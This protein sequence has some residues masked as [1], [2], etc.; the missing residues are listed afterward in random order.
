M[1]GHDAIRS[2]P[3]DPPPAP[4]RPPMAQQQPPAPGHDHL[5]AMA[6]AMGT[7]QGQN[8]DAIM[9]QL[10]ALQTSHA[11]TKQL[12]QQ[13]SMGQRPQDQSPSPGL[14]Q[15]EAFQR[16]GMPQSGSSDGMSAQAQQ[17][18]SMSQQQ[19]E[20]FLA[21]Q[22]RLQ[23]GHAQG[24]ARPP[25][26]QHIQQ[27]QGF[28]KSFAQYFHASGQTPP[29]A[30]F[31]NGEREGCFRVG[32]YWMDVVDLLMAVM[33]SGGIMA[34]MQQPPDSP[35]WRMLLS[36]KG[37]PAVLP[38]PIECPKPPNSDPNS[39]PT[40]TTNPVT[41]LSSAYFAWIQGFEVNMQKNR[42]ASYM[43]QQQ[44]AIAAGRPPPAPPINPSILNT[45]RLSGQS[46]SPST[47]GSAVPPSPAT[48]ALSFGQQGT[49]T[50][51]TPGGSTQPA[52]T[53]RRKPSDKKDSL[54]V[55]T[56]AGPVDGGAD[57]PD[58]SAGGKKRKRGKN[59]KSQEETPA[60]T[61]A[62]E[63]EEP[64]PP[65]SPSKRQ[66]FRVEYRPIHFPIPTSAGWD[67]NMVS[68]T[69]SKN[70]L[71]QGT[72]PIHDLAVVDMEAV[73][74]SLKSRMP[75]ELGYAVTVLA[76][77]SMPHPEE[78]IGGLP[79]HHLREVF[80]E[81]LDMTDEMTFG[82]GGHQA[83]LQAQ[84][85]EVKKED[86]D[87]ETTGS[88]RGMDH[89]NRLPFIELERLGKD[90]DFEVL[91]D[92]E[93]EEIQW[94]KDETGGRT[95][96]VLACVNIMRNLSMLSENQEIMAGYPE[97]INLLAA[98]CDARLCRLPGEALDKSTNK[99]FSV[100]ELA[101]VRRDFVTILLN[102]GGGVDLRQATPSATLAVFRNLSSFLASGWES[103]NLREPIY[104]PTL[105]SSIR[106][107]GPPTSVPS[108]GRALGAFS[109][110][111][112]PD[113]NREVLGQVVPQDELVELFEN[114]LKLLPI[115]RRHFEAMH[116]LEESLGHYETLGLALYSLAFLSPLATRAEMRNVPGSL[117]LI[118]R[119]IFDTAI[120]KGHNASN[121]FAIL[122]RRLC[123]T[124]GV[125]NGT[126]MPGGA[127]EGVS[128]MSFGGGGIEGSG[129]KFASEKVEQAWLAGREE[130]VLAALLGVRD[131]NWT[132][133]GELDGMLWHTELE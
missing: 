76:M 122:C 38:R 84:N 9:K 40:M 116:S 1:S 98:L 100:M 69:Y 110:L 132:A 72:R 93:E 54:S 90:F 78:N 109:L 63:P 32:E 6:A 61:P 80:L 118:T 71:R 81:L 28:L 3:A 96:L 114:L 70:S 16:P 55:N 87:A 20:M 115:T 25:V 11:R 131:M 10:Q 102:L 83:W 133:L 74:M 56:S 27:R 24:Q 105:A 34:A 42:Q 108:V 49:P 86:P 101:R 119:V 75:K 13:P 41:Y 106:E 127:V 64:E 91:G 15:Q 68:A 57:T 36:Q 130:S 14:A 104:G 111:T 5:A 35:M 12:S 79:L 60:P 89:L 2:D 113:S 43:R 46:D 67:P 50:P 94:R 30:I 39:P 107:T 77:L 51:S 4:T 125:L 95:K 58:S 124:L 37:I 23:Q 22:Q 19:R 8:R 92:E 7:V 17:L 112:H 31:N 73:L 128:G 97:V 126:V 121:P 117:A 18:G 66:R 82:E 123:E 52:G 59:G 62:P 120:Q 44:A 88:A 99:P 47:P 26:P 21:Q 48:N 33:K 129:W 85:P 103:N 53:L 65:V 29:D 45:Q